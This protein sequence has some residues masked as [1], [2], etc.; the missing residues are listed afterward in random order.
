MN[1]NRLTIGELAARFGLKS[2]A[3][4]FYERTGVLPEAERESGRRRYGADGVRRLEILQAAKRAGFSLDETK[5][6][7]ETVET[8]AP[9]FEVVRE[10]AER[11]LPEIER[12]IDHA[13]SVRNLMLLAATCDCA[14]FDAC[15]LFDA[16]RATRRTSGCP[17]KAGRAP[18][19]SSLSIGCL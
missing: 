7:L 10:L 9:A 12:L 15:T 5:K 4:R 6:L 14:S 16:D 17:T 3:I 2:S 1:D 19:H 13:L 8:G 18:S 11:K